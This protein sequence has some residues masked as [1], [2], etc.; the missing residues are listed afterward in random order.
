[1]IL[2]NHPEIVIESMAMLPLY[3]PDWKSEPTS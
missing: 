1:M 3:P 2:S